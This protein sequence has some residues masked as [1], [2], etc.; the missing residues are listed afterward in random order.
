MMGT[1]GL[2]RDPQ[3][4]AARVVR[5]AEPN[6]IE[7]ILEIER[8]SFSDPWSSASFRPLFGRNGVEVLVASENGHVAG[9]AVAH[10]A[11]EEAEIA[12]FA[13]ASPFRRRGIGRALLSE[14]VGRVRSAGVKEI[15]LEVRASNED[16]KALYRSF[17]F[18]EVSRRRGYYA[19]PVEDAIC[20]RHVMEPVKAQAME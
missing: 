15:W 8:E 9:F 5:S 16:A 18:E 20:M 2:K 19:R 10:W 4:S 11:G 3:T 14:I 6:D 13:V 17:G 7:A 1:K 12:N